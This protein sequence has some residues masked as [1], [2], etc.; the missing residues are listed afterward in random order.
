MERG[1]PGVV[2]ESRGSRSVDVDA[3]PGDD[4]A[5]ANELVSH[6]IRGVGSLS[7]VVGWFAAS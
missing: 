1:I 3:E 7:A 4:T 5:S 6:A 2:R